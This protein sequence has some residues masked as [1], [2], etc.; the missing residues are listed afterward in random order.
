MTASTAETAG[1]LLGLSNALADAV[2]KAGRS[3]VAVHGRQRAPSSGV[4]WQPGV[5]VTADHTLERD[6]GIGI[7]LPDGGK[8][9]ASVAGRDPGT[10]LAILRLEGVSLTPAEIA[11]T[12][13]LKVGHIVLAVARPG[14]T[15]LSASWGAVSAIG[16][17][18]RTWTG[19]QIDQL[20]R[21]DLTLY[22][23]FSG[24]PLVDAQGRVAGINTSGLSRSTSLAIPTSTVHRVT[25]QLL[26]KGRIS[27]GYLGLGLQTLRLP[28]KLRSD[29]SLPG[30]DGLIVVS[31]ENGGPGERAGILVGDIL[32]ALN[33]KPIGDTDAVQAALGPESVGNTAN[34][35]V[36]RGGQR[37]EVPLTIGERPTRGG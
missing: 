16:G 5:V 21:I 9:Q 28:D 22:P 6:E 4:L 27:R 15:G 30:Q 2:E 24:G 10:D 25:E 11:D 14:E 36:V 37:A 12:A 35:L 7:T 23:G 34:L 3:I 33:E 29:L 19:G 13:D 1:P 17:S 31:V 26:S 8:V 18:W 32:V 20:V